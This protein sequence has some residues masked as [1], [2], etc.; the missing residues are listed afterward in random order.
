MDMFHNSQRPDCR[1]PG[2]AV[3]SGTKVRIRLYISGTADQV[4][5]RFW[6]GEETLIPMK[7]LGLGVYESTITMP[8]H[9]GLVWYDFKALNERGRWM[10]YGNAKDRLG[11]VGVSYL[12]PPPAYQITVY[13]P[14]FNPPS[15]L[16][17]GIMYQIFPDRFHRSHMPTTQRTDVVLHSNWNEPPYLTA[18]ERSGDNW[19]LDFFGGNLEGIKQKL[20]YLKDLGITVLYLNPIFKARTNHRYDT[21]DYL[22]IDPLLGTREDFHSLCKEAAAM[23]IRVLLDGVFSHTGE[24]SLYFNRYGSYPTL[25]AYQSKDSPYYSWYQFRNHPNNYASWWN[26]PTLPELNKKDPSCRHFFLG[27]RGVARHWIQEGAAGWRLDVADELPMDF[28]RELR[29]SVHKQSPDAVLLGEVWEDA[30]NKTAYG[31]MR[32]YVTGDTLDSVMNYPLRDALIRFLT[33]DINAAQVVR[34]IRSLQENYPVPFFY[35]L[36]N[37]MGSH[38]RARLHNLLVKQDYSHLPNA[39]RRGLL[40]DKAHKQLARERFETMLAIVA[41]LPGM[42]SMYYGDEVG[43]E[44]AADP[45]CRGTYPWDQADKGSLQA[46]KE[47]FALRK[48]RPV[49]TRGFLEIAQE[50]E[51]TLIIQ[52]FA[53]DG[54]DVFGQPLLDEPYTLR[55]TRDAIRL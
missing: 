5:L 2:G 40:M 14:A 25:G 27:P 47:A 7:H 12:D 9:P 16:R 37:L 44:G 1:F 29:T 32:S 48:A 43:M 33:H 8:D 55:V 54:L 22:T 6:N 52:R 46:T 45:F 35:S 4:T 34:Q 38:D 10:Y 41:A 11:G 24:D 28:L 26:I 39:K 21:G 18:D 51:D 53:K 17:E 42:P 3:I 50:G 30:S 31:Q 20:P 19:A 36:M 49:L 23:G 13:D 15:F